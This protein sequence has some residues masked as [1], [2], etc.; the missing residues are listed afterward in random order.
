M[1]IR[2]RELDGKAPQLIGYVEEESAGSA[3]YTIAPDDVTGYDQLSQWITAP[4]S[5]VQSLEAMR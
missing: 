4:A 1:S 3:T 2:H 5:V